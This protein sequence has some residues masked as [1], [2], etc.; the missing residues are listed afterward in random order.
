MPSFDVKEEESD[1]KPVGFVSFFSKQDESRQPATEPFESFKESSTESLDETWVSV[2][3]L[4][5]LFISD[6]SEFD[7]TGICTPDGVKEPGGNPPHVDGERAIDSS[8]GVRGTR[9][10]PLDEAEGSTTDPSDGDGDEG[11]A[12]G[13]PEDGDGPGIGPLVN[14]VA[15]KFFSLFTFDTLDG[16]N[17]IESSLRLLLFITLTSILSL[18]LALGTFSA[19]DTVLL[20]KSGVL[21]ISENKVDLKEVCLTFSLASLKLRCSLVF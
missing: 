3:V 21:A 19:L 20:L 13:P 7:V 2:T 6:E 18:V 17:S 4:L 12:N 5:L 9:K 1:L 15:G 8:D 11:P 16:T 10:D 14:E